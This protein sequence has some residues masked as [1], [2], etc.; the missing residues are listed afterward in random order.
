MFSAECPH[1]QR[2]GLCAEC[3]NDALRI[4]ISKLERRLAELQE[5]VRK[6]FTLRE[7]KRGPCVDDMTSSEYTA[8][9]EDILAARAVVDALVGG[10]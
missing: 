3:D 9:Y 1:G 2:S 5:A 8:Y 4:Q 7:T 6:Y 10:N